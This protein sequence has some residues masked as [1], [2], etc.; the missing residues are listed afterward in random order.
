MFK[1]SYIFCIQTQVTCFFQ[2]NHIYSSSVKHDFS[3]NLY[4]SSKFFFMFRSCKLHS[5][6][7]KA[8]K[9]YINF[10]SK[11]N[12]KHTVRNNREID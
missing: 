6:D 12:I 1:V 11:A 7:T 10:N 2:Y 9:S 3:R 4:G 8:F 5:D